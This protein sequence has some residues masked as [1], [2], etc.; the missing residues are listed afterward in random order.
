MHWAEM[1]ILIMLIIDFLISINNWLVLHE[2][3]KQEGSSSELKSMRKKKICTIN[4]EARRIPLRSN[5]TIVCLH[6]QIGR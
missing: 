3:N 2:N 6:F 1:N 4:V 5:H